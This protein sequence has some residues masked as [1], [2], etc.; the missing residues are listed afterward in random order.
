MSLVLA[1]LREQYVDGLTA[2]RHLGDPSDAASIAGVR[3]WVSVFTEA[4]AVA[5]EQSDALMARIAELRTA[6]TARVAAHRASLGVRDTPRADSATARL[7][8]MLP[9]APV[10]TA[11]TLRRILGVSFPVASSA[12]GEHGAGI[13]DTR[14]IERNATAYVATEVLDLITL[15]ERRL[16]STRFDTRVTSPNR[17][18]PARPD[19]DTPQR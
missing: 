15:A 2:Y 7:L 10:A 6:W 1:T 13:L 3:R 19:R 4:A 18:V 16:A 9:E 14:T 8:R 11:G 12:L 17:P 5:A